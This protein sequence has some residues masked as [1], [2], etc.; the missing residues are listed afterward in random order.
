M[1]ILH[2]SIIETACLASSELLHPNP[3]SVNLTSVGMHF[4]LVES[5][6]QE[7]HCTPAGLSR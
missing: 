7:F 6:L 5:V 4:S 3:A 1:V 2:N